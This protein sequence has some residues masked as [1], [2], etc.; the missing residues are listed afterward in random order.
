V[1][2]GFSKLVWKGPGNIGKVG[3]GAGVEVG[4]PAG[5]P[6]ALCW[7]YA[8]GVVE[9]VGLNFDENPPSE[10]ADNQRTTRSKMPGKLRRAILNP[11]KE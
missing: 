6:A 5:V 7:A 4:L 1:S 3:V 9:R 10:Q 11:S 2:S 8:S